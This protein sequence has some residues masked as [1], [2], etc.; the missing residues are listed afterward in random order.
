M[1]GIV[2]GPVASREA[3]EK[4]LTESVRKRAQHRA[5]QGADVARMVLPAA[6]PGEKPPLEAIGLDVWFDADGMQKTYAEPAEMAGLAGLF[7]GKPDASVWKKPAGIWV[8]W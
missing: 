7:T 3:A 2:R 5:R 8:E 1:S 4:I 6:R